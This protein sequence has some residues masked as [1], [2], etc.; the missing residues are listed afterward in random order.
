MSAVTI[1]QPRIP[2][3]F[4]FFFFFFSRPT[5]LIRS[6]DVEDVDVGG[7]RAAQVRD[8]MAIS[9]VGAGIIVADEA[10]SQILDGQCCVVNITRRKPKTK[11]KTTNRQSVDGTE[12]LVVVDDELTCFAD[13]RGSDDGDAQSVAGFVAQCF[14]HFCCFFFF[15]SEIGSTAERIVERELIRTARCDADHQTSNNLYNICIPA[16]T[17]R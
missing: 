12:E 3:F 14:F 15:R 5:G 1:N 9:H 11:T 17:M 2:F 16:V 8:G 10:A 7:Q 6:R 4:F 13:G